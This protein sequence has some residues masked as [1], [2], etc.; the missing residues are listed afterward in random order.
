MVQAGN[1][2][3]SGKCRKP[4]AG[5][6]RGR[7]SA[8]AHSFRV[9]PGSELSVDDIL[10]AVMHQGRVRPRPFPQIAP[11]QPLRGFLGLR[12]QATDKTP[13]KPFLAAQRPYEFALHLKRLVCQHQFGGQCSD[14]RD[15]DTFH[16]PEL[17]LGTAGLSTGHTPRI[18]LH[19]A[20]TFTSNTQFSG[21]ASTFYLFTIGYASR[22]ISLAKRN[23]RMP[24]QSGLGGRYSRSA[25]AQKF[26]TET[27][28]PLL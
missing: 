3:L 22:L 27:F 16:W 1:A 4:G 26:G 23:P 20:S 2:A 21:R 14:H 17:W 19:P 25:S 18:F 7:P 13:A 6:C 9:A 15:C 28:Y 8:I 10:Q 24:D 12:P 11:W 5:S